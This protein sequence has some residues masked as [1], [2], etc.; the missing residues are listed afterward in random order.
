MLLPDDLPDDVLGA[1]L[2]YATAGIYGLPIDRTAKHAGSVLGKGWPAKSSR[3][4]KV[5]AAWFAGANHGLALHLGRSGV[6]AFDV[7]NPDQ[8]PAVLTELFA[9]TNPPFQSTRV[10][11]PG[12]GHYLFR[13]P[14]G[15]TIGNSLGHLPAGWGDIRG[16]NGIIVVEPTVH[17][18]AEQGGNA[19]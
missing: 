19:T 17:S 14:E 10:G 4:P 2:G 3:D 18:K 7:D 11:Q 9:A 15:R 6:M 16:R 12:R 13:V 5:I 1:A 8:L